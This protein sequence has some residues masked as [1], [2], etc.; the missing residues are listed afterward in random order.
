MIRTAGYTVMPEQVYENNKPPRITGYVARNSIRV[1]VRNIELVGKLIDG[2]LGAGSNAVSS[3]NFSSSRIDEVRRQALS[4]AVA[5]AKA[6]ADAMA[7]AAGGSLGPLIEISASYDN[8]RPIP[9]G[10]EMMQARAKVA[11]VETPISP[12]EQTVNANVSVR[13][14]FVP[15]R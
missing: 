9:Y 5:R 13:W 2:A 11:D 14:T 6:D 7:R 3:L 10:A 1:D 12:G 4:D 15:L 8:P